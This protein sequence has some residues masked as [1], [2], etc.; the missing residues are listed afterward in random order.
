VSAKLL[1]GIGSVITKIFGGSAKEVITSISNGLDSL[2]TSKEEKEAAKLLIEKEVNRH[3]E[4]MRDQANHELELILSD[5]QNAREMY[6]ASSGLQKIYAIVFLCAY[7]ILTCGI[8]FMI[9]NIAGSKINLPEW[10]VAFISSVWGGM[11]AK[12]STVTDFLFGAGMDNKQ[13]GSK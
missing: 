7:I 13:E 8:V 6:K 5:K 10:G 2:L 9:F 11:S 3:V 1:C 12:V 4:N